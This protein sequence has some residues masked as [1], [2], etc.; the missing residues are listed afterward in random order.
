MNKEEVERLPKETQDLV[1]DEMCELLTLTYNYP[2][3][4]EELKIFT[5]WHS[6]TGLY[7][8][9]LKEFLEK[10]KDNYMYITKLNE[11]IYSACRLSSEILNDIESP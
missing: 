7:G 1:F 11:E 5:E 2:M 3:R 9:N 10:S 6:A 8:G 4:F